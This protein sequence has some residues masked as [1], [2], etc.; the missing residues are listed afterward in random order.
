MVPEHQVLPAT[1]TVY[2]SIKTIQDV[3][4]AFHLH[5]IDIQDLIA[6]ERERP[7]LPILSMYQ[8]PVTHEEDF[9]IAMYGPMQSDR[10]LRIHLDNI[11][12]QTRREMKD[13]WMLYHWVERQ[14]GGQAD[15]QGQ[16]QDQQ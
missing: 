9:H 13:H 5:R 1:Q 15:G 11:P 7:P 6:F 16:G 2:L 10:E 8:F 12:S 3:L 4:A 14:D